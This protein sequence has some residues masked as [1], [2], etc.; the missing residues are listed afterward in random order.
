MKAWK[1][2]AGDGLAPEPGAR[3]QEPEVRL[4]AQ[5]GGVFPAQTVTPVGSASSWLPTDRAQGVIWGQAEKQAVIPAG[6]GGATCSRRSRPSDRQGAGISAARKS[7]PHGTR[8]RPAGCTS[9]TGSLC[10]CCVLPRLA[11]LSPRSSRRLRWCCW[12][13]SGDRSY[14]TWYSTHPFSAHWDFLRLGVPLGAGGVAQRGLHKALGSALGL[15]LWAP[16][17]PA[18]ARLPPRLPPWSAAHRDEGTDGGPRGPALLDG[19]FQEY[20]QPA[21]LSN[22]RMCTKLARPNFWQ[23]WL[24]LR[25]FRSA[26]VQRTS[27]CA[28][29]VAF[30][31]P[32]IIWPWNQKTAL[33]EAELGS[34]SGASRCLSILVRQEEEAGALLC[35]QH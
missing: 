25:F 10:P 30:P 35:D 7:G 6:H 24:D 18:R 31:P 19:G 26:H 4:R 32:L 3:S 11:P 16:S 12:T 29:A 27:R 15:G 1:C 20:L 21:V 28:E 22:R 34:S 2:P 23:V 13:R 17:P 5:G 33:L 14:F 9:A 8:P